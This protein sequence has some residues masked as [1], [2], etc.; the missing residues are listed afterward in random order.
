MDDTI[1]VISSHVNNIIVIVVGFIFEVVI[2]S[3]LII[4]DWG[5]INCYKTK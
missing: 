3:F 5:N 4:I 1:N 2:F